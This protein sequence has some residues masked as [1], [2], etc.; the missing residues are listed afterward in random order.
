MT[1]KEPYDS[2]AAY[3]DLLISWKERLKR[4]RAF[5]ARVFREYNASRILDTACGTGKHAIA[6]DDWGY[7]VVGADSSPAM[8]RKSGR[9]PA[10]E[11]SSSSGPVSPNSTR[12]AACSTL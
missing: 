11:R 5:F 10:T 8:V 4:E 12:S 9:M 6:F 7:H 1:T 2:V 3:Y